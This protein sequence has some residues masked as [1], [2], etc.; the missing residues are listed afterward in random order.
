MI[1]RDVD[2]GDMT[3]VFPTFLVQ[4]MVGTGLPEALHSKVTEPPLRT[5]IEPVEGWL[6]I[7]GGTE[8]KA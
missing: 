4:V 6:R 8:T 2:A 3:S 7:V 1:T 5:V